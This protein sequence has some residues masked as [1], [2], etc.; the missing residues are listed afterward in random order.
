MITIINRCVEDWMNWTLGNAGKGSGGWSILS[1][2]GMVRDAM[3]ILMCLRMWCFFVM[4]Q[5]CGGDF[6]VPRMQ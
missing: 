1:I 2:T 3:V 5:G 4:C 6:D